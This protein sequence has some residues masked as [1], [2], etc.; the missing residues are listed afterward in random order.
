MDKLEMNYMHTDEGK[1]VKEQINILREEIERLHC[2]IYA[3]KE[4]NFMLV[5][6]FLFLIGRM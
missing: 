6:G 3:L 4:K 2:E 1:P 5:L